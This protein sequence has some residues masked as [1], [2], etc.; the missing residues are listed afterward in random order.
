MRLKT[1]KPMAVHSYRLVQYT[2]NFS[3]NV[4]R[5]KI[6]SFAPNGLNM[7]VTGASMSQAFA[8]Q[9]TCAIA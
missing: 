5:L 1:R 6:G 4:T 7:V 8:A 9:R 3:G 2:Y